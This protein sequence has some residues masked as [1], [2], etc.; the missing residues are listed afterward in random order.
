MRALSIFLALI[1]AGFFI[2]KAV[3]FYQTEQYNDLAKLN[4]RVV[5]E[6]E[7][8]QNYV[9]GTEQQILSFFDPEIELSRGDYMVLDL[10]KGEWGEDFTSARAGLEA[11]ELPDTPEANALRANGYVLIDA[12]EASMPV[13]DEIIEMIVAQDRDQGALQEYVEY[14]ILLQQGKQQEAINAFSAV[15]EEFLAQ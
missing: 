4:N 12:F 13:Y 11:V 3:N 10:I 9:G 5:S 15:Q 8:V 6:L 1:A 7:V 2:Y 14:T